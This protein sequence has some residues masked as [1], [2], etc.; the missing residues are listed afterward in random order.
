MHHKPADSFLVICKKEGTE[1]LQDTNTSK[2]TPKRNLFLIV[3]S[4][5]NFR[6]IRTNTLKLNSSK[7]ALSR[8]K[9]IVNDK[10]TSGIKQ[11][12]ILQ[13]KIRLKKVIH[14]KKLIM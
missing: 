4:L 14:V 9:K 5:R 1:I 11:I 2:K 10:S 3:G 12:V 8:D 13:Y 7:K 6:N